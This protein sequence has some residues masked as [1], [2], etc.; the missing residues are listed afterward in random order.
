M[1]P[2]INYWS[3]IL[4]TVSTMIVESIWYAPKVFG[5]RWARLAGVDMDRPAAT[6]TVAIVVTVFVSF[7]SAWVLAGATSIAWHFYEGSY[8][9]SA[10]VTGIL[11]WAGFTAS[12]SSRMTPSRGGRPRSR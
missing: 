3:V 8:L 4:A 5:T 9:W 7:A 10:I 6:A 2:E 11:L 12:R 1:I